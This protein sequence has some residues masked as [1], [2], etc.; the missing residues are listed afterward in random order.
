[1]FHWWNENRL[2]D[3]HKRARKFI[4]Q[5]FLGIL[6]VKEVVRV[7][8][9]RNEALKKL[10]QQLRLQIG[11]SDL[12][13]WKALKRSCDAQL[14]IVRLNLAVRKSSPED[15]SDGEVR[16]ALCYVHAVILNTKKMLRSI[17]QGPE[18]ARAQS[19]LDFE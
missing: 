12:S 8:E 13:M 1:M 3:A 17:E 6:S 10:D 14:R 15:W 4:A 16:Y 19:K 5:G 11:R 18:W 7:L 2:I 9:H